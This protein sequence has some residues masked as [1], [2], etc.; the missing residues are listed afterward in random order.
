V[1]HAVIPRGS[2]VASKPWRLPELHSGGQDAAPVPA[3]DSTGG[4]TASSAPLYAFP[5]LS[6]IESLRQSG[7]D[8]GVESG[9]KEIQSRLGSEVEVIAK[10][11]QQVP[12]TLEAIDSAYERFFANVARE[13]GAALDVL[14][15]AQMAERIEKALATVARPEGLSLHLHPD[16]AAAIVEVAPELLSRDGMAVKES[17]DVLR[18]GFLIRSAFGSVDA[19]LDAALQKLKK[20]LRDA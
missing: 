12:V 15:A 7:Y 6:E 10:A 8:D 13:V 9:R 11:L 5:T 2:V 20:A 14:P 16:D 4:E 19:T 1:S 17:A 3:S 18:G